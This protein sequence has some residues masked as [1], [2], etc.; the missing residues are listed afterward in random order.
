M[1][2]SIARVTAGDHA[3]SDT[4]DQDAAGYGVHAMAW[5]QMA[6]ALAVILILGSIGILFGSSAPAGAD[7]VFS[8]GEVLASVGNGVVDGY[9]PTSGSQVATLVDGTNDQYDLGSAFDSSGN[10]YVTDD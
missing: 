3:R 7:T 2:L 1:K 6:L 8:T 9:N 4:A 10:F 5:R